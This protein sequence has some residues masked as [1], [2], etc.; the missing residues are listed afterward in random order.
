MYI[1]AHDVMVVVFTRMLQLLSYT[2]CITMHTCVHTQAYEPS[3]AHIHTLT[4]TQVNFID[5]S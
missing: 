4:R 1:H 3:H 5:H 2:S